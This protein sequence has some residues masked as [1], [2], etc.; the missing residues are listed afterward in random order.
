MANVNS[1]AQKNSKMPPV[2]LQG[3]LIITNAG[4]T[5]NTGFFKKKKKKKTPKEQTQTITRG[6]CPN[7]PIPYFS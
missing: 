2:L 6:E 1:Q 3:V 4:C 5:Q 7:D